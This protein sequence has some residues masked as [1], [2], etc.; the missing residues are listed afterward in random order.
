MKYFYSFHKIAQTIDVLKRNL[1]E[2]NF[3][4]CSFWSCSFLANCLSGLT[5]AWDSTL[6]ILLRSSNFQAIDSFIKVTF[7]ANMFHKIAQ[8]ID[9]L[10]R[11]LHDQNECTMS[12]A[13]SNSKMAD[14]EED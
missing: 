1:H 12:N 13:R 11:N 4:V 5:S 6:F 2:Q 9:V 10:K 7:S 14:D 3:L 8:T